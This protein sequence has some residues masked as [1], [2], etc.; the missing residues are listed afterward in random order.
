MRRACKQSAAWRV[1]R[2]EHDAKGVQTVGGPHALRRLRACYPTRN[3][4]CDTPLLQAGIGP[5]LKIYYFQVD[6]PVALPLVEIGRKDNGARSASRHELRNALRHVKSDGLHGPAVL[7][8]AELQMPFAAADLARRA[9][10]LQ[11]RRQEKRAAVIGSIG[12]QAV[13]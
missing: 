6:P 12:L 11:A 10:D 5:G 3:P 1:A 8:D 9:V 13:Q 4:G 2:P 7:A